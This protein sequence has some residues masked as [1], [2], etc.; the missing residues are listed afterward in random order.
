MT[1]PTDIVPSGRRRSFRRRAVIVAA[2][3][4]LAVAGLVT[5]ATGPD[6]D[7]VAVTVGDN[8]GATPPDA[9]P[10]DV[11]GAID[12]APPA[13]PTT[14]TTASTATTTTLAPAAPPSTVTTVRPAIVT[15]TTRPPSTTT[16]RPAAPAAAATPTVTGL[17]VVD[18]GTGALRRVVSG[19]VYEPVWSPDGSRLAFVRDNQLYV[20]GADGTGEHVIAPSVTPSRAAW[21][22]DGSSL[23][24]IRG[25]AVFVTSADGGKE[26]QIA[27]GGV[28]AVAWSRHGEQI[29]FAAAVIMKNTLEVVRPDG[30]D[31]RVLAT[32][33]GCDGRVV[34]SPD[35]TRI[36]YLDFNVGPAVVDVANGTRTALTTQR[37]MGWAMS[38][39]PGGDELAFADYVGTDNRLS[40]A[41]ADGS[42]VRTIA[43]GA[44][45]PDW[46]TDGR[47][48]AFIGNRNPDR[49]GQLLTH[50][51]VINAAGGGERLLVTDT[52]STH[53]DMPSWAPDST[54]IAFSFVAS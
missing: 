47:R 44:V 46:A 34:W 39:S 13:P 51:Y 24:F 31:R 14:A 23:A 36:G 50:L 15:P 20:V 41:R 49:T 21:S 32:S 33:I 29:A 28:C 19:R 25:G 30:T 6:G 42:G 7:D 40:I 38:W 35:S 27:D 43:G 2:A 53:V 18:A 9:L 54:R 3:A 5:M 48:I 8:S 16:T 22:P 45:A 52:R 11:Q 4:A 10:E 37:N 26:R 17:Y 12:V 1:H